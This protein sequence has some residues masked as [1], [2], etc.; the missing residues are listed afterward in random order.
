MDAVELT[1]TYHLPV[2]NS[3]A[4]PKKSNDS[5][6]LFSHNITIFVIG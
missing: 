1:S 2:I 6:M 3:D 4:L 5:F